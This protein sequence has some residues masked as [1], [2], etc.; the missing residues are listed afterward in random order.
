VKRVLCV[1]AI[2]ASLGTVAHAAGADPDPYQLY[3]RARAVWMSQHY[4]DY[5]TYTIA[6]WVDERGVPKTAHYRAVYDATHDRIYMNGVS[7]EERVAPHVPT[8]TNITLEPKRNWMT[9]FKRHVGN[10]EDAVDFLGIP[11]LAPNYSFGIAAYVPEV[12][13]TQT[14]QAALV[15][16]IRRQFNDPMSSQKAQQLN[17]ASGLKEIGRVVSTD[18]DYAIAYAGV[19]TVAGT[20]AYHLMLRPLQASPRLRLRQMWIDTR[21]FTTV[22]IVIQGN[23]INS[24]VPWAVTFATVNGAQYIAAEQA[25]APVGSGRHLYEQATISFESV[26]PA[27][28]GR[29]LWTPIASS[30]NVLTEPQ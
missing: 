30:K 6:V 9:L 28:P 2:A 8:G 24:N 27:Q 13:T 11:M 26:G 4:P 17:N 25:L 22:R 14:D 18:R 10:P 16:E 23:F 5:V 29:Y 12:A 15:A 20:R 1:V 21:T 3:S 7:E 19:D